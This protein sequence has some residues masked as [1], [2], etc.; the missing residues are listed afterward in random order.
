MSAMRQQRADDSMDTVSAQLRMIRERAGLTVRALAEA[1][2]A[3][4]SSYS[5]Y[6]R[7]TFKQ[8]WLPM[9]LVRRLMPHLVGRG[10]PPITEADVLALAG[11][12]HPLYLPAVTQ[13]S[14]TGGGNVRS[15]VSAPELPGPGSRAR[16]VPLYAAIPAERGFAMNFV[17]VPADTAP[18][19]PALEGVQSAFAFY[20]IDNSMA[21]WR[22]PG[23]LVYV[24][25][26]RPAAVGCHVIVR[27][28]TDGQWVLR[29]LVARNE[30]TLALE[31]Y[32]PAL[33]ETMQAADAAEIL[34]V[35]EWSEALG[36]T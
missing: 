13:R 35:M 23:E 18:R 14:Q 33:I 20:C 4:L 32:Q 26:T 31:R 7:E 25:P 34:R 2:E 30:S 36:L 12:Q 6:E 10:V 17:S 5:S 22:Q 21:P 19:P 1:I 29:K 16:D 27:D 3:P 28:R 24:L 11:A 9:K 8:P 15:A